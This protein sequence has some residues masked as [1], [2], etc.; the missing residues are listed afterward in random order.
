[1]P[2]PTENMWQALDQKK[3]EEVISIINSHPDL[4]LVNATD[5]INGTLLMYTLDNPIF[6]PRPLELIKFILTH[7]KINLHYQRP[8]SERT[9]VEAVITTNDP[10]IVEMLQNDSHFLFNKDKLTYEY[11]KKTLAAAVKTYEMKKKKDPN[12]ADTAKSKV[13]TANLEEMVSMLRDWTIR[14]AVAT[15]NPDILTQMEKAGDDIY[16]ALP[17]GTKPI[18]LLK[19]DNNELG[20]WF[21][22]KSARTPIKKDSSEQGEPNPQRFFQDI[23][24]YE[25]AL[26]KL[27]KEHMTKQANLYNQAGE[28]IR[29]GIHQIAAF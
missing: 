16:Q 15:D 13:R 10:A 11:V 8:E 12:S 2:S 26:V 5:P 20:V 22:E 4:D 23:K 18:R 28:E 21:K 17:D 6:K 25:D 19:R 1:M 29:D 24:K 7:S 27:Q 3:Y 9:N 14:H